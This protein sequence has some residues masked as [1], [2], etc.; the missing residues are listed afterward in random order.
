MVFLREIR[1]ESM[2]RDSRCFADAS[3]G[4]YT[5]F[6]LQN[7]VSQSG[8]KLFRNGTKVLCA[9]EES[10]EATRSVCTLWR[11]NTVPLSGR[12]R[13]HHSG[14]LLAA[15]SSEWTFADR[16]IFHITRRIAF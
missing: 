7:D 16:G 13:P 1:L 12:R 2:I 9:C 4:P 6:D 14:E 15:R 10:S 11:R 8:H 5:G 3:G